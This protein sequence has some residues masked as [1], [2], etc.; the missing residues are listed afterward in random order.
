MVGTSIGGRHRGLLAALVLGGLA[1]GACGVDENTGLTP[2]GASTTVRGPTTTAAPA[3]DPAGVLKHAYDLSLVKLDPVSANDP[4]A[5]ATIQY[6]IYDTLLRQN[7]DG[8]YTPGLAR[9]ATLVD[10]STINVTLADGVKFSDGTAVDAAAVKASI[11]RIQQS[12]KTQTFRAEI[13]QVTQMDVVSP[14]QLTI[15][16]GT[17]IAGA[18]YNLLAHNE[19]LVVSP[20]ALRSGTSLDSA[21]VG[22]G[23]FKLESFAPNQALVLV[24][25]P[26]FFQAADVKLNK[27]EF[28]HTVAG[29]AVT[30]AL[31][32]GQVDAAYIAFDQISAVNG[33]KIKA[34]PYRS[35]DN[36]LW[37]SMQCNASTPENPGATQPALRDPRVRQA[38]NYALD[39]EALNNLVFEGQGGVLNGFW[40]ADSRYANPTTKDAF[41]RDVAR[42][43]ALLQQA[44]QTNLKLTLGHPPGALNQRFS[45][46]AQAQWKEAGIDVQLV[47]ITDAVTDYYRGRKTD[48]FV[49]A[50]TRSWTDKITRNFS[51]GSIGSVCIGDSAEFIAKVNSLRA[52]DPN[53]STAL[54]LWHDIQKLE[55]DSALA[56]FGLNGVAGT[57]FDATKLV[58]VKWRPNQLG[59]L[60]IDPIATY[61]TKS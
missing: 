35:I 54:G 45:E 53:S 13:N 30:N 36:V 27:I 39:K 1:L 47:Q 38:L 32:A 15:R 61:V 34:E 22:A 9:S 31:K 8:S 5:S 48:M 12:K 24:K 2:Q 18:F 58:N 37:I 6:L 43:R 21:P 51:T 60:A 59:I 29:A 56:I 14:T 17:P 10:G 4:T 3:P 28:V 7:A 23:P 44:N 16:L 55:I 49:T 20:T 52:T 57:A 50:Q 33:G 46:A 11:E 42:A 19:T 40:P 26:T 41:K 25:S